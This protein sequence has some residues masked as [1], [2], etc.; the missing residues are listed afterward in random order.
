[1]GSLQRNKAKTVAEIADEFH[2]L[3]TIRLA[4]ELDKRA[5]ARGRVLPCY[6]QVNVSGEETKSGVPPEA[7]H[8]FLDGLEEFS[9]LRVVG[10][11]TLASP[12][13]H[14]EDLERL[15]RPELRTLA[16]LARDYDELRRSHTPEKLRLSMGMSGD[17]E[18]AVEEGATDVRLGTLLF[19][20]REA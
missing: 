8:D 10:L 4:R 6:V 13:D 1:M 2:A 9:G 7:A 15:V 5:H 12:A 11:M 14:D 19:G 3:D 17:F 18:V 16:R 20:A